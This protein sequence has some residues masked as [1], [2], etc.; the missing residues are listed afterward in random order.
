[1]QVLVNCPISC[2]SCPEPLDLPEEILDL[3]DR[4]SKYGPY[5]RVEGEDSEKTIEVVRKT[6]DYM[7]NTIYGEDATHELSEAILEECVNREDLCSFW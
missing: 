6:V 5:Q 3:L 2:D 4:V 7:E 1:M